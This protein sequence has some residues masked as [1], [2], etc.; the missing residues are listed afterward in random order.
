MK[1]NWIQFERA[2]IVESTLQSTTFGFSPTLNWTALILILCNF[3][4][5]SATT[6][7]QWNLATSI[8]ISLQ[9]SIPFQHSTYR[10]SKASA[11]VSRVLTRV[12]AIQAVQ[13][14]LLLLFDLLPKW[15]LPKILAANT[16]VVWYSIA[17]CQ[18][19]KFQHFSYFGGRV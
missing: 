1:I 4:T 9:A 15:Y 5:C 10:I 17:L 8:Y 13:F 7:L 16:W 6:K 11:L 12:D 14:N 18:L 2:S 3:D 19:F